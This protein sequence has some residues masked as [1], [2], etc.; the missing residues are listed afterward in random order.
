[1]GAGVNKPLMRVHFRGA[2]GEV[3]GSQYLLEFGERRVLLECGIIQGGRNERARN[4]AAFGFDPRTL[5]AVVVSHAHIDHIGRLPL[6]VSRGYRGPI[7]ATRATADLARIMLEDSA[8]LAAAD[9]ERENRSRERRGDALIAPLYLL[10]DVADTLR[11]MQPLDYGERRDILPGLGLRF[12]D[13]GHIIGSAVVELVAT[14]GSE[15]RTLVF[16]GDIGPDDTPILR[17]PTPLHDAD[18]V[19]LESTYGDRNHRS[20]NET[21]RELGTILANARDSGGNVLIP[22]FAVGRTQ[23]ILFWMA[24]HFDDWHLGEWQIFLDSPMA[25][26]VTELYKRHSE[27]FGD[28]A[29]SGVADGANPFRMPNL[30]LITDVQDSMALNRRAGGCIIIA[31]SGMCNGGRIRHHLRH[32]LWRENCNIIFPG[33]Q[34]QG[35]LGRELVDGAAFVNVFGE[36]IR[37]RAQR[38]TIGGL[39][40]HADQGGL[41]AW[42]GHFRSRPPVVLVHGEDRARE[43]LA[44]RLRADFRADVSLAKAGGTAVV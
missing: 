27:L 43:G 7:Y 3:T 39:S 11:L 2:A 44:A 25:T 6:L 31:G 34:A 14:H 22:A 32:N 9:A 42:Y 17:D 13:A 23:E 21:V 10:R 37:V 41:A 40:A 4:A 8:S 36:R 26:K 12:E 33:Y 15:R 38:H 28:S 20:R 35:T 1:M 18:L 30:R 29:R 5:D 16:S 19:L 24:R